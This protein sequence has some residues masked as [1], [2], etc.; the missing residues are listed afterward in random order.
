MPIERALLPRGLPQER[1]AG[2]PQAKL[3]GQPSPRQASPTSKRRAQVICPRHSRP[4]D[5]FLDSSS[6]VSSVGYSMIFVARGI[7]PKTHRA[8]LIARFLPTPSFASSSRCFAGRLITSRLQRL[9]MVSFLTS[10]ATLATGC[11]L[12]QDRDFLLKPGCQLR[13][14]W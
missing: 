2:G 11:R 13:R 3:G 7:L 6:F 9:T 14:H 8:A 12:P 1:Y 5:R 10:R 4:L